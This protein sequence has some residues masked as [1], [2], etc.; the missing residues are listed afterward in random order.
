MVMCIWP[1]NNFQ[2]ANLAKE[3]ASLSSTIWMRPEMS[4]MKGS[5]AQRFGSFPFSRYV[6]LAC[7]VRHCSGKLDLVFLENRPAYTSQIKCIQ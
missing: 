5:V 4:W 7:L 6:L 3:N 1:W 2:M